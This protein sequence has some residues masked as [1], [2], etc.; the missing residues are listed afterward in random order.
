MKECFRWYGPDDGV[1]LHYIRQAGAEEVFTALHEIPYGKIWPLEEILK[2][3]SLIEKE[4]LEWSVVESLPVHE[5]IKT[6]TGNFKE[7]IQSYRKS[8]VNLGKAGL[9][10]VVY[11]FMPVLDWVRTDLKYTLED[12]AECLKFDPVRF[13]MFETYLLKRKNVESDYTLGQLKQA[14]RSWLGM[15]ASDKKEFERSIIDIFPGVKL[16]LDIKDIQKMMSKYEEICVS[17]YKEHLKE[18]LSEMVPCAEDNGIKMAIHPDD[19]PISILGLPRIVSTDK[20]L[21]DVLGMYESPSNG[22]CFCTGSLSPLP[23]NDLIRMVRKYGHRI[24]AVHLRSTQRDKDGSFYEAKH[25]EGSVDMFGVVLSLLQEQLCR[26]RENLQD[27]QLCF[28]PD[29]GHTIMDDLVKPDAENPGYSGI[30]RMRGLA[31]L[32]GLQFGLS[33]VLTREAT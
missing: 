5:D 28:R 23:Q 21:E 14:E 8:L 22:L 18:F 31:E 26:S 7:F 4:G 25:L 13:A 27:W 16:G 1:S 20:D 6:R 3:K 9:K 30:G 15:S 2:R 33:H 32:R 11:N 29:H 17:Q 12:G 19:P 10:T 24:N